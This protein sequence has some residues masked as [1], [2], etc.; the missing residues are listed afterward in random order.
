M[1]PGQAAGIAV[2]RERGNV[3]YRRSDGKTGD[4][5]VHEVS[6]RG[7]LLIHRQS[8]KQWCTA[9]EGKTPLAGGQPAVVAPSAPS[10]AHQHRVQPPTAPVPTPATVSESEP[11]AAITTAPMEDAEIGATAPEVDAPDVE[12]DLPEEELR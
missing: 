8:F 10:W 3:Q 11:T 9:L 6:S 2:C 5:P 4:D 7:K 1:P 12:G